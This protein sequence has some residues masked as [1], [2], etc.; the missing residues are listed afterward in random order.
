ME[1]DAGCKE[2]IEGTHRGVNHATAQ[3]LPPSQRNEVGLISRGQGKGM[4]ERA[5]GR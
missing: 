4:W 3:V 2:V 1:E 5:R